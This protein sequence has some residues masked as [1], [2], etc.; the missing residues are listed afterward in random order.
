MLVELEGVGGGGN[1]GAGDVCL[2]VGPGSGVANL[3]LFTKGSSS[4]FLASG[5]SSLFWTSGS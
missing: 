4:D 1:G 2:L 5:G 3:T